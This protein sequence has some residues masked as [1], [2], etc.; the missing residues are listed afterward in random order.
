[1][2][3]KS[4]KKHGFSA[5][6]LHGDL[7]QSVRMKTLDQFKNDEVQLLVAS[8]VAARGLD[9]PAVSHIFN[10]DAPYHPDD[11]VHRIGR[12][13]RA[14]RSGHAFMLMTPRDDKYV[15]AIERLIGNTLPRRKID[16]VEPRE[17]LRPRNPERERDR[18][19]GRGGRGRGRARPI[20]DHGQRASMEPAASKPQD[21]I[22]Q[23]RAKKP[24]REPRAKGPKSQSEAKRADRAQEPRPKHL[25]HATADAHQLPA[26]LLRP[27]ALPKAKSEDAET[28]AKPSKPRARKKNDD[29]SETT[30]T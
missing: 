14:G 11:Y 2:V 23:P 9:I 28:A 17:D 10:F 27:V 20:K 6:P 3:A 1:M 22:E 26:F 25:E 29:A 12:T 4:L 16:G 21:G 7:D 24:K 5:A 30:D 13:G 19:R 8:D 15:D 18:N